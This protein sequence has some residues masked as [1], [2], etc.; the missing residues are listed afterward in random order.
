ME[1]AI[2]EFIPVAEEAPSSQRL[3][4]LQIS[5]ISGFGKTRFGAE[6]ASNLEQMQKDQRSPFYESDHRNSWTEFFFVSLNGLGDELDWTSIDKGLTCEEALSQRIL[7]HSLLGMDVG[8]AQLKFSPASMK[9]GMFEVLRA[10]E[11]YTRK[12]RH[13]YEDDRVVLFFQIDELP[14]LKRDDNKWTDVK[15]SISRMRS[16]QSQYCSVYIVL[17]HT[18][19]MDGGNW[20]SLASWTTV[21]L[22]ALSREQMKELLWNVHKPKISLS[23][24]DESR[25]D[26]QLS[27]LNGVTL[28]VTADS[29]QNAV[30]EFV[31]GESMAI[32]SILLEMK[33]VLRLRASS[34]V[35]YVKTLPYP[36][37]NQLLLCLFTGEN[38][39][40]PKDDE[41]PSEVEGSNIPAEMENPINRDR[42]FLQEL[43]RLGKVGVV[44]LV[45][46]A[47]DSF[48]ISVPYPFLFRLAMDTKF[49]GLDECL[50]A[51][52]LDRPRFAEQVV[53][54][55]FAVRINGLILSQPDNPTFRHIALPSDKEIVLPVELL[56]VMQ[57]KHRFWRHNGELRDQ[58]HGENGVYLLAG[59]S[60]AFDVMVSLP[61]HVILVQVKSGLR[62]S[63]VDVRKTNRNGAI[64]ARNISAE[65]HKKVVKVWLTYSRVVDD[66]LSEDW[67]ILNDEELLSFLPPSVGGSVHNKRIGNVSESMKEE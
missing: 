4:L 53:A 38:I 56:E 58:W 46:G 64:L 3:C 13:L 25:L 42:L 8:T 23:V 30:E 16:Y 5:S 67:L 29:V 21:P 9:K 50:P 32:S 39:D 7:S 31:D 52:D 49:L 60:L 15:N 61:K 19:F 2:D 57:P 65:Y 54:S 22:R 14:N 34:F 17:T 6:M 37:R 12:Y 44:Q 48:S 11:E 18:A 47:D 35:D 59:S 27:L 45:K 41:M 10:L 1:E 66:A 28:C 36:F 62:D 63:V 33:R 55:I 26:W 20:S 24:A 43:R 40:I 51:M